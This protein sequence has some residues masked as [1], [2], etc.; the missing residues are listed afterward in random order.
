MNQYLEDWMQELDELEVQVDLGIED[1]GDAFEKQKS[2]LLESVEHLQEQVKEHTG[3]D[4]LRTKLDELRVQ[5]ALGKADSQD[6]YEAQKEKLEGTLSDMK[7]TLHQ[8]T[9]DAD[10]KFTS[11]SDRLKQRATQF[12]TK[13]DL[14]KVQYALGK[15]EAKEEWEEKQKEVREKLHHVRTRI[16]SNKEKAEDHWDEFSEEISEAFGHFKKAV[17]G[18]FS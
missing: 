3:A 9:E 7:A 4:K 11:L 14:F 1:I 16:D 8:F 10:E 17:K 2:A 15:A 6:A 5:L 13:M 18:L 12:E